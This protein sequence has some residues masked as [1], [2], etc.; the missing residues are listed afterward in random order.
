MT[1][2]ITPSN[3]GTGRRPFKVLTPPERSTAMVLARYSN[4]QKTHAAKNAELAARELM[5]KAIL[6]G[7]ACAAF[8]FGF[9]LLSQRNWLLQSGQMV[10]AL[11]NS[12]QRVQFATPRTAPAPAGDADTPDART[13]G[14]TVRAD[15]F[16][17]PTDESASITEFDLP[18]TGDFQTVGSVKLRLMGANPMAKTYDISVKTPQR[19]FYRQDVKLAEHILLGRSD[20]SG[21]LVVGEISPSSV[22][23]YVSEPRYRGHHRRRRHQS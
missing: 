1:N 11:P 17:I 4:R 8:A 2:E 12:V 9:F 18:V 20:K 3:T 7:T 5:W 10:G 22:H 15:G 13:A 14:P 23:G 6:L 19:E 16:T 21:E